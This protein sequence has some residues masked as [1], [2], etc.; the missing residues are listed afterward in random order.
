MHTCVGAR[1]DGKEERIVARKN[2][3]NLHVRSWNRKWSKETLG[4]APSSPKENDS[5]FNAKPF[6]HCFAKSSKYEIKY[7][8]FIEAIMKSSE[9]CVLWGKKRVARGESSWSSW[10][11]QRDRAN[12]AALKREKQWPLYPKR[13]ANGLRKQQIS[14]DALPER[15]SAKLNKY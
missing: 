14:D 11:P 2:M 1:Q 3:G 4:M 6:I 10:I 5:N 9:M 13:W 7:R 15:H 8:I 12:K